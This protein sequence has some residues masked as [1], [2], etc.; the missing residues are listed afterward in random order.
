MT[1]FDMMCLSAD[2]ITYWIV[3]QQQPP[4]ILPRIIDVLCFIN[5]EHLEIATMHID[6]KL[7]LAERI[8]TNY[9][10]ILKNIQ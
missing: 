1:K 8:I 6:F 3:K 5:D 10:I 2:F 9:L 7:Q 4:F